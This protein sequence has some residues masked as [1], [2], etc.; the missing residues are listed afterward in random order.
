[1]KMV[2]RKRVQKENGGKWYILATL[3]ISN[4]LLG[5][6]DF[7]SQYVLSILDGILNLLQR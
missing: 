5:E 2:K 4:N 3:L 7:G 1:M 6:G